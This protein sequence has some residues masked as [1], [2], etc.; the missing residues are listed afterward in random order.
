MVNSPI[1]PIFPVK[2]VLNTRT[3]TL[4]GGQEYESVYK[5]YELKY[6]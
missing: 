3:V 6:L 4:F 1:P 5:T 2:I